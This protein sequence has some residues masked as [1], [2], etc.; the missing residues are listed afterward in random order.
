MEFLRGNPIGPAVERIVAVLVWTASLAP[1]WTWW[2]RRFAEPL[3]LDVVAWA[4]LAVLIAACW[5]G[6]T[7]AAVRPAVW[8][9]VY[10]AVGLV[11]FHMLRWFVPLT[12]SGVCGIAAGIPL[13]LPEPDENR[14]GDKPGIAPFLGLALMGLPTAMILDLFLGLPL[15]ALATAVAVEL[16]R[17]VGFPVVRTGLELAVGETS[18]WVDVPCA[19]IHMLGAGLLA[20]FVLAAAFGFRWWRTLVLSLVAVFSVVV[21]NVVRIVALTLLAFRGQA[22]SASGHSV[23]GCVLLLPSVLLVAALAYLLE[24]RRT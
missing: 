1:L 14:P 20:A 2:A 9:L 7:S 3:D 10:A 8:K 19:G 5:H 11:A 18:V 16:L 15:R 4:S 6:C 12:A 22:L 23:V 17:L 13:L 24:R 21:A